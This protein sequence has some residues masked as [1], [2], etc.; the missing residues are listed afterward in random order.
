METFNGSTFGARAGILLLGAVLMIVAQRRGWR[1]TLITAIVVALALRGEMALLSADIR[2]YDLYNDFVIAGHNALAHRDLILNTRPT[3]WNYLPVYGLPLG[4]EVWLTDHHLLPWHL[5]GKIIPIGCDIAVTVLIGRLATGGTGALR[6]FQYACNPLA[7]LVS[8]VHGQMEP[9]CLMF[10]VAALL[11]AAR[12]RPLLAGAL[13][14]LGIGTKTWPAIL[15]PAVIAAASPAWWKGGRLDWR[16]T[17]RVVTGAA[18]VPLLLFVTLPLT[19]GT[20]WQD[21]PRIGKVMAGYHSAAGAWGWSAP[22]VAAMHRSPW[23]PPEFVNTI[24]TPILLGALALA[25]WFWRRAH[26][27]DLAAAIPSVFL[28]ATAGFGAQY[29][30]WPVPFQTA[31]PN[32]WI[33]PFQLSAAVYAG[34]GYLVLGLSSDLYWRYAAVWYI[35]SFVVI[36]LLILALPARRTREPGADH[37]GSDHPEPGRAEPA[38]ARA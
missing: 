7:I 25:L 21:L 12:R 19:T 9:I 22:I 10:A 18:G 11:A 8:A 30:L 24:G 35:A 6:R 31:R 13:L 38:A 15:L 1:P 26:P 27:V 2:P 3:G 32:R 14:G 37:V 33:I 28:V 23:N 29:L 17:V 4:A 36:V 5:A 20:H 34:I 16:A